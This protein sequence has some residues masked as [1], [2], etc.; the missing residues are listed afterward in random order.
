MTL[1]THLLEPLRRSF[2]R[3]AA[4]VIVIVMLL[5]G[6]VGLY[7]SQQVSAQVTDQRNSELRTSTAQDANSLAE[8]FGRQQ[9]ATQFLSQDSDIRDASASGRSRVMQ[10]RMDRLTDTAVAIH[11]V[12]TSRSMVISSTAEAVEGR[13]APSLGIPWQGGSLNLMGS[14]QVATSRAFVYEDELVMAFA[15]SV[16]GTEDA[17][18]VFHSVA[19]RAQQFSRTIDGSYTYVVDG[20]GRIQLAA[21]ESVISTTYP[22]GANASVL[23]TDRSDGN[24]TLTRDGDTL[25]GAAPIEGMDWTLLK[26]APASNAYALRQAVQTNLI[27]LILTAFLGIAAL[28]GIVGRDAMTSLRA[29]A[30]RAD[31]LAAGDLDVTI[32]DSGRIDEVGQVRDSFRE[33]QGYLQTVAD[34]ADA[35]A[36]QQFDAAVLD[37]PVPG[38]LGQSLQAMHADLQSFIEELE[39]AQAEAQSSRAEAEALA[40]ELESQAEEVRTVVERAADGD[41]TPRL[42]TDSDNEAMAAIAEAFNELLDELNDTLGELQRFAQEVDA[43]S[44]QITASAREIED[45]SGEVSDS[46]QEMA[47]GAQEQESI[48]S[49]VSDE[50]TNLS[51]TIEEIASSAD[52][53]ADKSESA[54]A[55]GDAGHGRANAAI[56]EMGAVEA[57]AS[58]TIEAVEALDAEMERI[59]EIVD[60]I[61]DIAEQTNMLALNASIEAARAGEAGEGFAVVADEIKTLAMETSEATQEIDELITEVQRS[62]GDAVDDIQEMGERLDEGVETVEAA[63]ESL[64]DI[65]EKVEEANVGVQSIN[66]ATDEQASSTEEVVAMVDDVGDISQ[67]NASKAQTAAAGVEQQTATLSDVTGQIQDLSAQSADLRDLLAA[68]EVDADDQAGVL[69]GTDSATDS[70]S[71]PTEREA[72]SDDAD[73][74]ADDVAEPRDASDAASADA[75]APGSDIEPAQGDESTPTEPPAPPADGDGDPPA[76][77]S[78]DTSDG[79]MATDGEGGETDQDDS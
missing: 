16:S 2:L 73:D 52:E 14:N 55:A 18:Y 77:D 23:G 72:T 74:L 71:E 45:A 38:R 63:T 76:A 31:S 44:D 67:T 6:G 47:D 26:H 62:T 3:K 10:V 22:G 19:T 28:V 7:T 79:S 30:A 66:D 75:E 64:D 25:V 13:T 51:A 32:E 4:V 41:L 1:A 15:S 8:W 21:N 42:D 58:E 5:L 36:N 61:D 11:Y 69:D 24:A 35:L 60:L 49:R 50:M 27:V 65:V 43:S 70:N 46:V 17:V 37:E 56:E 57:K 78:P 20:D 33:I 53:V 59:G 48:V 34:Q 40:S 54:A 12:N 29:L 68:F 39:A 9:S